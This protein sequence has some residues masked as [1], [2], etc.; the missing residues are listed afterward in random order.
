MT[1]DFF[2]EVIYLYISETRSVNV[3]GSYLPLLEYN[4]WMRNSF[5]VSSH[6]QQRHNC[7]SCRLFRYFQKLGIASEID[8]HDRH[9][10]T[11]ADF[12]LFVLPTI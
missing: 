6:I 7:T 3:L 12:Q 8:L 11:L 9:G 4:G 1:K 10:S 2:F 5:G